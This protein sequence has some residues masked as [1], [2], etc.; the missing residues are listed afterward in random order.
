MDS[1]TRSKRTVYLV[2]EEALLLLFSLCSLCRSP[3]SVTKQVIGT[4]LR[5]KQKCS[6]CE[7]EYIWESQPFIKNIPAGNILLSAAILLTGSVQEKVLHMLQIIECVTICSRTFFAHQ[8]KYLIPSVSTVWDRYQQAFIAILKSD[9]TPLVIGGD[10][11]ADSP[12]HTAKYG[13]YSVIELNHRAVLD[14]QLV[15]VKH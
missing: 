8:K 9:A 10:G 3:T 1:D 12:G 6:H 2:F 15:Q 7:S 13:S 5:I 4:F 11:R 14:I